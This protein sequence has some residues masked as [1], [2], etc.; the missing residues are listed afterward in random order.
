MG[1]PLKSSIH[2]SQGMS[3]CRTNV[4]TP[5]RHAGWIEP[6]LDG[7]N[8]PQELQVEV[9][10]ANHEDTDV[11]KIPAAED[12]HRWYP[13]TSTSQGSTRNPFPFADQQRGPTK[14]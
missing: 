6:R 12:T 3:E 7:V 8:Y 5:E 4:V 13:E 9:P 11:V 10:R 1:I 2:K 14:A